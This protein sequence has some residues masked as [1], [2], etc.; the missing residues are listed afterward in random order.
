MQSVLDMYIHQ[1]LLFIQ[2]LL[3]WYILHRHPL[4]IGLLL[5]I[6]LQFIQHL[7][8]GQLGAMDMDTVGDAATITSSRKNF[9][10]IADFLFYH[11]TS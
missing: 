5:F 11:L 9:K 1:H 7:C 8:I 2:L 3:L 4:Y 10:K 6:L